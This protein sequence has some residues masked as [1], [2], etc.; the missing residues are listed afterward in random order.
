MPLSWERYTEMEE[1][2]NTRA[3]QEHAA[4]FGITIDVEDYMETNGLEGCEQMPCREDCPL[5]RQP[6]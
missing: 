3:C 2:Q 4:K 5:M 1:E 6:Y